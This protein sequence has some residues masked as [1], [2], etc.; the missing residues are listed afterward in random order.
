MGKMVETANTYAS[1][2]T[3]MVTSG[4]RGNQKFANTH[5]G[6]TVASKDKRK[7]ATP[8]TL[9]MIVKTYRCFYNSLR[10]IYSFAFPSLGNSKSEW[11]QGEHRTLGPVNALRS[12]ELAM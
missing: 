9:T 5:T 12:L 6:G 7:S 1:K 11:P 2:A 4:T 10:R 3:V 8:R